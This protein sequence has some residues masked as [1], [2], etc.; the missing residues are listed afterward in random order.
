VKNKKPNC[1]KPTTSGVRPSK[2]YANK[3]VFKKNNVAVVIPV[4][5]DHFNYI[6]DI[7]VIPSLFCLK[8]I[9]IL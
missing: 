2:R 1:K 6:E 7:E 5:P 3:Y 8:P 9:Y 4:A